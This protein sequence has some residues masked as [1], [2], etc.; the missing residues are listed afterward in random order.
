MNTTA[1]LAAHIAITLIVCAGVVL[2]QRNR[3]QIVAMGLMLV[4]FGVFIL[5]TGKYPGRSISSITG[6]HQVIAGWVAV[7]CGGVL[8]FIKPRQK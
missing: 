1:G 5:L 7:I 3:S 8:L 6:I 4:F 2:T